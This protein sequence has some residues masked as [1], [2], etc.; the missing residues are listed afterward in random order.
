[1]ITTAMGGAGAM[2]TAVVHLGHGVPVIGSPAAYRHAASF[3]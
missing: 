1:M 3:S 2:M